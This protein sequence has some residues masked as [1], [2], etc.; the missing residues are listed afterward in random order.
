MLVA[1]AAR[2]GCRGDCLGGWRTRG[3]DRRDD[4][5]PRRSSL[6]SRAGQP[7][8]NPRRVSPSLSGLGAATILGVVTAGLAQVS[9]GVSPSSVA[10][11][12]GARRAHVRAITGRG[13]PVAAEAHVVHSRSGGSRVRDAQTPGGAPMAGCRRSTGHGRRHDRG[14]IR[15]RQPASPYRGRRAIG[16]LAAC[17]VGQG[18]AI[19]AR[20]SLAR[21]CARIH[22]CLTADADECRSHSASN[23]FRLSCSYGRSLAASVGPPARPTNEETHPRQSADR[24]RRTTREH[25]RRKR[26]DAECNQALVERRR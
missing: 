26:L 2:S 5:R 8:V 7:R 1:A 11:V 23:R 17:D 16:L 24:R 13:G 15:D 4:R 10:G 9:M 21:R 14:R 22:T 20:T 18:E 3:A 19:V 25:D 12:A 6:Q